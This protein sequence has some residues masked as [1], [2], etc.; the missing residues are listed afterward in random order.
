MIQECNVI[1][2]FIAHF[3]WKIIFDSKSCI[4][5]VNNV[6]N[7]NIIQWI[8]SR[9]SSLLDEGRKETGKLN[10]IYNIIKVA[11]WAEEKKFLINNVEWSSS[12]YVF[13]EINI[14][15]FNHECS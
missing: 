8:D 10:T 15:I 2:L 4:K 12:I 3:C 1:I 13:Q 6:W 9:I 5:Y 7:S 14:S 11:G